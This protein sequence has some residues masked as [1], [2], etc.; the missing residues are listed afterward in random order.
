MLCEE[1]ER[2][3]GEFDEII[4]ALE[5]PKLTAKDKAALER[6]YTRLSHII[7]GHRET[8]HGGGPCFEE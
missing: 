2:L 1:L 3:E 8:G 5:D 6:E 7:Q 4:T